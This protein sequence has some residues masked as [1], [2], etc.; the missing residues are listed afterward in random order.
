MI[1]NEKLYVVGSWYW[2]D[3][4]HCDQSSYTGLRQFTFISRNGTGSRYQTGYLD[5]WGVEITE[6]EALF[7]KLK[8]PNVD[9]QEEDSFIQIICGDTTSD[10]ILIL[11]DLR[12]EQSIHDQ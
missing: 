1:P 3:M 12:P 7:I 2:T 8:Y 9:T 10:Q 5:F 6:E 4:H 11:K